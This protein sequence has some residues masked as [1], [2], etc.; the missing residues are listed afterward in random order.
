MKA[1]EMAATIGAN[2]RL[3]WPDLHIDPA[4]SQAQVRVIVLVEDTPDI[5]EQDWLK[6][7]SHNPAF[8]FLKDPEED[9]Y[10][11]NDGKPFES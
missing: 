10:T 2:G 5:P 7:A 9:I 8:D 3:I 11:L 6:S 1:Y 4:L